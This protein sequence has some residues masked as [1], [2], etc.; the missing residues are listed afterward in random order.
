MVELFQF[1]HDHIADGGAGNLSSA[2]L[3]KLGLDII[4]K[5]VHGAAGQRPF[6]AGLADTPQE[7]FPVEILAPA[8]LFNNEEAGPLQA[9]VG[10]ETQ[11]A[12][13]ALAPAAYAVVD[14]ARIDN[15]RIMVSA[16]GA[17]HLPT[18]T[19]CGVEVYKLPQRVVFVNRF[20]DKK[21][22]IF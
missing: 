6:F 20:S 16:V 18:S 8:I 10:G 2:Y 13:Q 1:C 4:D 3:E 12:L 21:L 22:T 11:V 7:L 14:V 17:I 19:S 9:L 5:P 15:L